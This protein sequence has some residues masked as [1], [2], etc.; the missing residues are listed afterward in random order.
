MSLNYNRIARTRTTSSTQG[1]YGIRSGTIYLPATFHVDGYDYIAFYLGF[2]RLSDG[3]PMVEAGVSRKG[4][5]TG[6]HAFVNAYGM[7]Q[8]WRSAQPVLPS[9][10]TYFTMQLISEGYDAASEKYKVAF[11]VND[12]VQH[13]AYVPLGSQKVRVKY[14]NDTYEANTDGGAGEVKYDWMRWTNMSLKTATDDT[15]DLWKSPDYDS[16]TESGTFTMPAGYSP[17]YTIEWVYKWHEKRI[18]HNL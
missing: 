10:A 6:W 1:F 8:D 15:W 18:K 13:R 7:D 12:Q 14:V 5:D 11:Y 17:K 2:D 16:I 9:G 4:G 3:Q